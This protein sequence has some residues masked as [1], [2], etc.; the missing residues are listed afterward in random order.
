MFCHSIVSINQQNTCNL[1]FRM[2]LLAA[3]MMW[4]CQ[5]SHSQENIDT[6]KLKG[7]WIL[8]KINFLDNSVDTA[9]IKSAFEGHTFTIEQNERYT[10]FLR[11]GGRKI[12]VNTGTYRWT[13]VPFFEQDGEE[14]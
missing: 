6:S 8:E 14:V 3:F 9:A 2:T 11:K 10:S 12:L 5:D 13:K 1:F 7:T 4:F